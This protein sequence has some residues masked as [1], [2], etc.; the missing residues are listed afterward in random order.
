M[1]RQTKVL[2]FGTFDIIHPGH[3][4]FIRQAENEGDILYVVIARDANVVKIKGRKSVNSEKERVINLK[5]KLGV[6]NI[7]LGNLE[8][9]FKVIEKIKPDI[10]CL[11]YDQEISIDSL[12]AELKKRSL[13]LVIKR[14]LPYKEDSYKSSKLRE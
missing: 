14:L 3:L 10:I 11:G 7:L 1:E 13:F 6:K 5:E 2:I 4:S 12:T 8:D 9:H